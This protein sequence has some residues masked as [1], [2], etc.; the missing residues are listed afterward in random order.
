[1]K[2]GAIL[3]AGI[4]ESGGRNSI[5]NL[6]SSQGLPKL[7]ACI[8]MLGFTHFWYWFPMIHFFSLS[9]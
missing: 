3:A 7:G 2:L 9:L 4:L 6:A 5:I 1:M 8:G